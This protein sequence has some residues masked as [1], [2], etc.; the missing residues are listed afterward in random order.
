MNAKTFILVWVLVPAIAPAAPHL[1]PDAVI[2]SPGQTVS[3]PLRLTGTA[4]A[5]AGWNA[6]IQLPHRLVLTDVVRGS[7][8]PSPGFRLVAQALPDPSV[9]AVALL[10]YSTTQ[11]I[12]ST[13]VLCTLLLAIPADAAPG[14]YP[15][16]LDAPDRSSSLARSPKTLGGYPLV[17]GGSPTASPISRCAMA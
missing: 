6:T 16:L 9:N 13:G 17:V 3:V 15:I 14:D 1:A 10:A 11:S 12:S 4:P 7:L 2:G 8:L 5:S